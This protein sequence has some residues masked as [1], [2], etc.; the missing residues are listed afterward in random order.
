MAQQLK[1]IAPLMEN[2]GWVLST[3]FW[4]LTSIHNSNSGYLIH[5]SGLCEY[6]TYMYMPTQRHIHVHGNVCTW[7]SVIKA[8]E[9][10]SFTR[11]KQDNYKCP[12]RDLPRDQ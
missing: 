3:L 7:L 12:Q 2:V 4:P 9:Q 6:H 10:I 5:C 1:S 8:D 11:Q